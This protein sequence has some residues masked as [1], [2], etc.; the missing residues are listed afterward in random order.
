MNDSSSS[1]A[2]SPTSDAKSPAGHAKPGRRPHL[3][4]T[5]TRWGALAKLLH[6]TIALLVFVQLPLGLAAVN[7]ALSPTK[8]DLYV[9][10]KSTGLLILGMMIARI[11]WRLVNV[12]PS[13]PDGMPS[14]ERTAARWSHALL[15]LLLVLLP[16]TGWIIQS[17]SNIPFR[18]FW[19]IPLP[20]IV[21]PDKAV[22]DAFG[23]VHTA[24]VVVLSLLLL[25]HIGAALRHHFVKRNDVLL[26][27][28]PGRGGVE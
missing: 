15:Y 24:L 28:L 5:D 4:N 27:M 26:R 17:A 25:A 2:E 1:A 7:W 9:W 14:L 8:L 10:H 18:V 12:A 20:A 22:A 11:A 21:G 6:W 19:R 3:R 16:I 23:V 13:L